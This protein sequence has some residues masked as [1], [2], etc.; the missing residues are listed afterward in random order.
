MLCRS[1]YFLFYYTHFNLHLSFRLIYKVCMKKISF[2]CFLY[3]LILKRYKK[4]VK[5]EPVSR[6]QS[7]FI[8][9]AFMMGIFTAI[10]LSFGRNVF[11]FDKTIF[12]C[13]EMMIQLGT[14]SIIFKFLFN[15][16]FSILPIIVTIVINVKILLFVSFPFFTPR[17]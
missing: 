2:L 12:T 13:S 14:A 1:D 5:A 3:Y 6:S 9:I 8:S 15:L 17:N 10:P 4:V 16:F 7:F 11:P